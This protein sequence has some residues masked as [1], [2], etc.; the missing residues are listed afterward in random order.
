[1]NRSSQPPMVM[2]RRCDHYDHET[3][4][5]IIRDGIFAMGARPRGRILIKPNIVTAN[6]DYIHHSYTEPRMLGAM[7]QVLREHGDCGAITVGESGGIGMPSRLFFAESGIRAL[8][9]SLG[10]PLVDFN[11][12]QTRE[13]ALHRAKW[14]HTVALAKSILEADYR[15]WMPKL[16]F[17]IVTGITNALKLNMGILTHRERF[18]YHDDRLH[19]KIVDL[20]EPGYPDLIVTDAVTIGRGFESSPYPVHLGAVLIANDPLAA[21][22]VAAR[23]LG[24]RPQD[25]RHL[26]E[27]A[28]RGYGSLDMARITITGD[29]SIE[30]LAHQIKDVDSPFQDLQKLDTPLRFYE[31]INRQSGNICDGGCICSIKGVLGTAEKRFP[32]NLKGARPGA[33]VMGYYRGE[34]IHPGQPVALIGACA[35]VDGRLVAGK[36]IRMRGCPVRVKDMMLFLLHRFGLRS[37]AFDPRNLRLLLYHS[38]IN[39]LMRLSIPLRPGARLDSR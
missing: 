13:V 9:R 17:H 39:G 22:M 12:E 2:L 15:V 34:V 8:C 7:V 20:L 10:V 35:G 28:H 38:L 31:G 11:E 16:K 32:G 25:I 14:H 24:Y 5:A 30:A 18:I 29:V 3:L 36:V 19:E 33:I 27:A 23:I 1:M 26:A 21:D 6:R 4:C 37:P